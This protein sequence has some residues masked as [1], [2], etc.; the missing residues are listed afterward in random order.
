MKPTTFY[1]RY[2][3]AILLIAVFMLP[4][5]FAGARRAMNSN[6][7]DVKQWL[8]AQYEETR[9]F[10][11]FR[12][13]FAG[14]EFV[15]VSWDGCRLDDQRV[16]L[17]SAKLVPPADSQAKPEE[18]YFSN[19]ISGPSV[20]ETL[21]QAPVNLTRSEA[22]ER[23][24]GSLIGPDREQTC[25]V[26][27]V[28]DAGKQS[29]K[30][31]IAKI[32]DTAREECDIPD[33]QLHLGGPTSDN[34]AIDKAGERSL[35]RLA[36]LAGA[37]GL[38]VSWWCLRSAKLVA[39]VLTTGIYSAAVSLAVVW[40]SGSSMNAI[41]L[42]MPSLVYVAAISG[43]IHLANYYRD[44]LHQEGLEGAPGRAV[45]HAVLPLFLATATTAVGLLTLCYSEL[46]P[47]QM[48][49]LYSAVGVVVSAVF[50]FLFLPA[51]LQIFPLVEEAHGAADSTSSLID[52][53]FF[54]GWNR[55][56]EWIIDHNKLVTACCLVAMAFTTYGMTRMKT[57]VQLL[58][59]FSPKAKVVTDYHWLETHLGEL[60][61]MEVV[62]NMDADREKC[63]LNFLQ[64]MQ[65]VERVQKQI[66]SI[67]EVGSSLSTVTFAPELPK[68]AIHSDDAQAAET[69]PK[70]K[71]RGGI[72]GLLSRVAHVDDEEK[73]DRKIR[74][75]KLED[76]RA[77]FL[78]G[79]YLRESDGKELW[80]ISARVSA[81]KDVD[82]A[83]FVGDIQAAVQPVLDEQQKQGVGGISATYTG[84]VPLVYK[85]QNS[86]LDGLIFGFVTDLI[87]IVVTIIVVQ[88][89]LSAGVIL[90]LPSLI[91]VVVVFGTMGW[92]GI[93]IDIGTVMTP[94]VAL[95]VSVDDIVHFMLQFRRALAAGSDRKQ[96]VMTAY[97]HCGR[98]MYQ[99]W[100][101]IG[102]G[103]SVFALSPFTPTQRFGYMMIALLT[104]ALV[105]NLLL[106]PAL[107][108]GPLG[109][110]YSPKRLRTVRTRRK[111]AIPRPTERISVE[112]PSVEAELAVLQRA[113]PPGPK[114][115][116][117]SPDPRSVKASQRSIRR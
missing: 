20:I 63:S 82:Y 15:L 49:G 71:R 57:S 54:K 93:I 99:S 115:L 111:P 107:L 29:L 87:L 43:A 21:T 37:I 44:T 58:R 12:R 5:V 52:P 64:R 7:N 74:N 26:L 28:A 116:H 106:L 100:G 41:V 55:V 70:T 98:A 47:I 14:E 2:S 109:A 53:A 80:R 95:G 114:W 35:V 105:G 76:H 86:L 6:K 112:V 27:S 39:I 50:L 85:A 59:L 51:T 66:E 72:G 10:R 77:D 32:Y 30:K 62:I 75:E 48:F 23:L 34:V 90:S 108:G 101:V 3:P 83:K 79:D 18:R 113:E 117:S 88:R 103:L 42:T 61:P 36:G 81:L 11:E 25:L 17:M 8:P 46:V 40:Y 104:T 60:I 89:S 4:I 38:I 94:A 31:T 96:A 19:I 24:R 13:H 110:L 33:D 45:A 84:L 67:D 9:V 78:A 1:A 73:L 102:L 56:G 65:L 22:I 91:P 92:L 68:Y 69:R 97:H 16:R